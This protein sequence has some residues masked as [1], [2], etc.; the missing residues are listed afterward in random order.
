M[1]MVDNG[2]TVVVTQDKEV[3]YEIKLI[4]DKVATSDD[5]TDNVATVIDKIRERVATNLKEKVEEEKEEKLVCYGCNNPMEG[6]Y[7][8]TF[9]KKGRK[10]G[11]C[12]ECYEKEAYV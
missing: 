3:K 10:L 5:N 9:D 6:I 11:V 4:G 1:K 2:D 7:K 12:R 8:E